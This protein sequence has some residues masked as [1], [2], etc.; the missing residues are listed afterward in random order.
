[1]KIDT[2][3][4]V[5]DKKKKEQEIV[6]KMIRIYCRKKHKSIELYEECQ[7]LSDYTK[8]RT[9]H[10]PFIEVKTFCA[11]CKVHC[12][13]PQMRDKIKEVMKFSGKYL[14]FYYPKEVFLHIIDT[15]KHKIKKG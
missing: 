11:S 4:Y 12:Y 5:E 14:I 1:M 10:C 13:K 6:E 9:Q 8:Q 7:K 15:I 3:K 2:I